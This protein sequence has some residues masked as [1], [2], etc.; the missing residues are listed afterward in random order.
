MRHRVASASPLACANSIG[1][2]GMAEAKCLVSLE[3]RSSHQQH[4]LFCE[5]RKNRGVDA[6][7][8]RGPKWNLRVTALRQAAASPVPARPRLPLSSAERCLHGIW[9]ARNGLVKSEKC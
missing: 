3:A 9:Y 4:L 8:E 1:V 2:H 6:S 7:R 5:V